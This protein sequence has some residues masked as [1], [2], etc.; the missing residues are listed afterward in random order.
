MVDRQ[1]EVHSCGI[2]VVQAHRRLRPQLQ[3]H[4]GRQKLVE[5]TQ[6]ELRMHMRGEGT[7][8]GERE[9]TKG[10]QSRVSDCPKS[11]TVYALQQIC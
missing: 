9:G 10:P 6:G 1:R 3:Q 8:A 5:Q 2:D 11:V 7:G 4:L